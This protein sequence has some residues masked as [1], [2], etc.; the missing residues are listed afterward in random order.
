MIVQVQCYAG[1]KAHERPVRFRIGEREF[2]VEE[3]VEQWYV[4]D[5]TFYRVHADDAKASQVR[6][7]S[8]G[9][10]ALWVAFRD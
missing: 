6:A 7:R 4:P 5:D 3:I 10:I 9:S 2:M 1:R 8:R